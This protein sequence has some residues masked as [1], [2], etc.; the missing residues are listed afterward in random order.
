MRAASALVALL[1]ALPAAAANFS[2]SARGTTAAEFLNLGAGA[3]AAAMGNAY[4]AGTNDASAVYWNPAAMT[5]VA[6][7]SATFMHSA[8]I[9]SSYFDYAGYVQNEPKWG[10]FGGALQYFSAGR[11]AQTD[12]TG[13]TTGDFTP[14]DMAVYFSY[15][16]EVGGF[17]LGAT[18][19]V[20]DSNIL[21]SASAGA[22]DLGLLSPKLFG[23]RLRLALTATNL[24][25]DTVVFSQEGAPLPMTFR[26]GSAFAA[27]KDLRAT[28]DGIFSRS[29]RPNGAAGLEYW[30]KDDGAWRFAGRAGFNSQTIGSIDGFTGVSFGFGVA[31]RAVSFDYGFT[32]LGG[33]GQAH[34]LSLTCDF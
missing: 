24:G 6:H 33:L 23:D 25:G 10:A 27:T 19:K 21:T 29:D 20:I 5:Q 8:Y 13:A 31:A 3:R 18:A 28:A 26:V 22:I 15:A 7:R 2:A 9:N 1:A 32:P 30:L 17:A 4:S 12:E 16:R 11:L 34:R 14:Y